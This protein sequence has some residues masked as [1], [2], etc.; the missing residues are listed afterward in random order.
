MK[1]IFS[2]H[3]MYMIT[4]LN[5]LGNNIL[6]TDMLI[7]ASVT[8]NS[9]PS[10]NIYCASVLIPPTELLMRWADGDPV[11]MQNQYP[12]YLMNS[13][14]ADEM[15]TS[16][17][18]VLMRKDVY[19]YIPQSEFNIFGMNLLNHIYYVYGI[20]M[21]TP[22]TQ[23]NFDYSKLPFILSKFYMFNILTANDFLNSYPGNYKLIPFVIN[24][25]ANELHPF[26]RP[27][28]WE[29]YANYFND[30]IVKNNSNKELVCLVKEVLPR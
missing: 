14:D 9:D 1:D 25:L 21:C 17:I 15:I 24:K 22:T 6:N 23:F 11:V 8:D 27:A 16:L 12:Q 7:V 29:E 3:K 20:T 10:Q 26:N 2:G 5:V 30:W 4:D 19:I 13:M 18:A 28:T